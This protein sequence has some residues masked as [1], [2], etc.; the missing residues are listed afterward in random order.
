MKVKALIYIIFLWLQV[1]IVMAQNVDTTRVTNPNNFILQLQ[2]RQPGQGF[3]TVYQDPRLNDLL[4]AHKVYCIKHPG[5]DG[6]RIRIFSDLGT[7]ARDKWDMAKAKFYGQFPDIP[8]YQ[9]YKNPSYKIY[10]GDYRTKMEAL[11]AL[12]RIKYAYPNAFIVP[13]RI[14]RPKELEKSK[15]E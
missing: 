3:V 4:D 9:E 8:I 2:S 14:N 7:E 5:L 11:K 1:G 15:K 6:Y 13:D 12:D 10:V